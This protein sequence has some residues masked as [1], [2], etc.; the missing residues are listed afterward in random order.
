MSDNKDLEQK[1]FASI[2]AALIFLLVSSQFMYKLT[3]KIGLKTLNSN[4]NPTTWGY[5]LHSIVFGLIVFGTMFIPK[6]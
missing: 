5:I 1:I 4:D 3:N 2:I 6:Y